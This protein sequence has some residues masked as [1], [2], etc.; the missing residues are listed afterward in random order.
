MLRC[1]VTS[2]P[3][4]HKASQLWNNHLQKEHG[5]F[6]PYIKLWQNYSHCRPKAAQIP[7]ANFSSY[8]PADT[9]YSLAPRRCLHNP[10][11]LY[12]VCNILLYHFRLCAKRL[13]VATEICERYICILCFHWRVSE[14]YIQF[15]PITSQ[16]AAPLESLYTCVYSWKHN[17]RQ[18]WTP[19][20]SSFH[21]VSFRCEILWLLY[22]VWWRSK[23][24]YIS[25]QKHIPGQ[26]LTWYD[27]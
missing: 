17:T 3:F 22:Y 19:I 16:T 15:S 11:G 21:N 24:L 26:N 27:K 1:L 7:A 13:L 18:I 12:T 20:C 6:K 14:L 10:A 9:I 23:P 5:S 4:S 2:P 25:K 8:K